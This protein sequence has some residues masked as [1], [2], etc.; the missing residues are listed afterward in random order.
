MA[1]LKTNGWKPMVG[2]GTFTN[3]ILRKETYG[4]T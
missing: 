3:Y 4:H 2:L 1:C